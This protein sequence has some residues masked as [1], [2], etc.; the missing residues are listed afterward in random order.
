MEKM[1][2]AV[3]VALGAAIVPARAFANDGPSSRPVELTDAQLDEVTAG[4]GPPAFVLAAGHGPRFMRSAG[5]QQPTASQP[6]TQIN[7]L[8][9][10]IAFTYNIGPN[11][12]VDMA[13]VLQLSLLSQPIQ[14]GSATA[15]QTG[16]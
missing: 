8:F 15:V 4:V 9:K 11:A 7:V 5:T 10:D 14:S 6:T 2:A 13:T 3:V 12:Q 1:L 16:H